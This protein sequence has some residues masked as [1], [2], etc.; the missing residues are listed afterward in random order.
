MS[1]NCKAFIYY[2]FNSIS[3]KTYISKAKDSQIINTHPHPTNT[4]D[5]NLSTPT[6]SNPIESSAALT[7]TSGAIDEI[8]NPFTTPATIPVPPSTPKHVTF[9]LPPD[10]INDHQLSDSPWLNLPSD[11]HN[12]QPH[13]PVSP[14]R[15]TPS[16][17]IPSSHW[18]RHST[19]PNTSSWSPY[20]G[21][22]S[23]WKSS[24]S[25]KSGPAGNHKG[26]KVNDVVPFF[27]KEGMR[28]WCI[29][30]KWVIIHLSI[31]RVSAY[32]ISRHEH[33]SGNWKKYS[34]FW[35][36]YW[37]NNPSP[38]PCIRGHWRLGYIM[39]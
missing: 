16:H 33:A 19:T 4:S 2:I 37:N 31:A 23:A 30:C 8:N 24:C 1:I 27:N 35:S 7:A 21:P 34:F 6:L 26:H 10:P 22:H 25:T 9:N 32:P 39:W 38:T 3:G 14:K 12:A 15:D 18:S 28:K 5:L 20:F 11:A 17:K 36:E 29:F 13:T